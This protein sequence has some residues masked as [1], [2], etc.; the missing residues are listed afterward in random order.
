MPFLWHA[1]T[2]CYFG[3]GKGE[4]H[5]YDQAEI[6]SQW[7]MSAGGW[8]GSHFDLSAEMIHGAA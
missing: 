7:C 8:L 6:L 4:Q 5:Q 1:S 2:V 3:D